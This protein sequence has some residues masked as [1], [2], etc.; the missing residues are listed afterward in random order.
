MLGLV[1]LFTMNTQHTPSQHPAQLEP[2]LDIEELANYLGIPVATIYD[3]RV[4]GHGPRAHRL[5][6]HLKFALSDIQTWMAE[7]R[8]PGPVSQAS[9]ASPERK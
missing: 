7:Q 9:D 6:K 4:R 8:E 5:G 3:W 1:H 2:L